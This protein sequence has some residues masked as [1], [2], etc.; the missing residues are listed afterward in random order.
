M[1]GKVKNKY[2]SDEEIRQIGAK[3][4]KFPLF[5]VDLMLNEDNE[6]V[7]S[8]EPDNV[9]FTIL[10][11]FESGLVELQEIPQLEQKLMPH[12]FKSNQKMHLK[13]PVKPTEMPQPPSKEDKKALPDENTWVY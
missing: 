13:V 5:S 9:V 7:F 1:T 12:L 4:K 3:K 8:H 2:Y 11:T 10:K 6:V